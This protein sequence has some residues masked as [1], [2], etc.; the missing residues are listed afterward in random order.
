MK[1]TRAQGAMEYMS[2]YGWA[3]MAVIVVAIMMWQ[4]GIFDQKSSPYTA[5]GFNY[6][7]PQLGS[8]S[9]THT[10]GAYTFEG[11]FLNAQGDSI[12]V[13]DID[14]KIDGNSCRNGWIKPESDEFTTTYRMTCMDEIITKRIKKA[15]HFWLYGEI[16]TSDCDG[17][18]DDPYKE[19]TT[20]ELEITYL[21]SIGD[22]TTT[23]TDSGTIE[24]PVSQT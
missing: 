14:F 20:A 15:E 6:I 8:V 19:I 22:A 24:G 7:K 18:W 21:V 12:T 17:T 9:I 4:F 13:T 1:C 3:I 2:T 23:K 16:C 11:I 5:K 10:A